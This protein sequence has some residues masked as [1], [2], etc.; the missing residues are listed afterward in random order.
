MTTRLTVRPDRYAAGG[1]A[2]A[3]DDDGRVVFVRGAIPGELVRA[4]VVEAKRDWARAELVSVEE[5]SPDRVV[6]PCH[7]RREGCGGCGMQHLTIDAQHEAKVAIVVDA[8]IRTGRL[9]EP[10]VTHGG[11]VSPRSYRTTIRVTG[12]GAGRAGFRAERSHD[13]V[14]VDDCLVAHPR[15]SALLPDVRVD[16]GVE[17]TLRTS[18]ATGEVVASWDQRTGRVHGLPEFVG[19]D[20]GAFVTEVVTGRPLRV[21]ARSFFQ[22]GPDA[23]ELLV[24]TVTAMAPELADAEAV[25]DAYAGVGVFAACAVPADAHVVVI[26]TSR[27]AVADAEANLEG[28]PG[29]IVRREVG[30]W[31]AAPDRDGFDVVIA[32]PARSGLGKPGA[33]A[34]GRLGAPVLV[35]VSCDPA[36]L[37]RDSRLLADHGYRHEG[38]TVVDVFPHTT[39]VETVSRFLR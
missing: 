24:R 36:S 27:W 34:L 11:A 5:T 35:L 17:L 2:I 15:L 9:G 25:V 23:A 29:E 10:A 32:D 3:R 37:A 22:S 28:R 6:P 8:L 19:S 18:V 21:S 4:D 7:W 14:A 20:P 31:R 33:N 13:V 30:G 12:D 16:P 1:D 26:E 38:T 39:Q